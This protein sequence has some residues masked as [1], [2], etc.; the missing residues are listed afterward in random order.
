MKHKSIT[1]AITLLLALAI[2]IPLTTIPTTSG[3]STW[4]TYPYIGVTPNPVGVGQEVLLHVGITQE[5]QLHWMGWE[6]LTVTVTKPDGTTETLGPF[7]TDS[8]GGTG[9]IY[10]PNMVGN[11]TLQTHFPQQL[12]PADIGGGQFSTATIPKDTIM[13]ESSSRVLTLVVQDQAIPI[14]P[15]LPLPTEYWTRP[16]DAQL[17]E[18]HSISGNWVTAPENF[19]ALYN[20]D[21]PETAH[22]LWTKTLAMGGL[23][24]GLTGRDQLAHSFEDGDAYEGKFGQQAVSTEVPVIIGGI[25]Y[26][27]RFEARGDPYAKQ[28]VVAVNLH[29]GEELWC[30]PL[31]G[32]TGTTTGHTV[33]AANRVI[34]GKSDQFPDGIG[35]RLAFGQAFY[36]DSFNYHGVFGYLW[37]VSGTTWMAFDAL[38]GRWIY[39]ITD[40]P[41]GTT[42]YGPS[43]ELLRIQINQ[44]Q[45]WMA[46]WNATKIVNAQISGASGDGSW[47]PHGN[48]YNASGN[49]A[50]VRAAWEWNVTI[51]TGL[52]GS[53]YR[54][55]LDDRVVG[56]AFN[57]TNVVTWALSLKQ[58]QVGQ[59]LFN[60]N[61]NAPAVWNAGN[62]TISRSAGSIDEG[63]ITYWS[64]E[65]NQHWAFSTNTGDLLWGPTAPQNYLDLFGHRAAIAYGKFFSQ[66][67]SGILYCYDA[68]TGQLL[69]TYEADD[70]YNQVLW[71]NQWHIR[72]LIITDGK[73][74]MGTSEHS[75]VDPKPKGG[76]FVCVDVE[77]GQEIWRADGLFRQTDWGARAIIGDSII[78]T[79]DTYDQRIYAIGRGPSAVTVTA[80]GIRTQLGT[81]IMIQGTV[82]DIS[83]GTKDPALTMRFPNGVPAVADEYMSDWMLYV[84]KQF[85]RP[86]DATG[87]EVTIDVID[88]N[89]N[90]RNIGTTTSDSSGFYSFEWQPDIEG[91][92]TIIASFAGSKSYWP[93]YAQAAFA[94]DEATLQPTQ[95]PAV[96]LP[97]TELYIIGTGIA[98]IA[99]IALATLLILKKR[100]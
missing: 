33:T 42:L 86:M 9:T 11:Y 45:G 98:I 49:H 20:E 92:Y 16:I 57:R 3:Q 14:W 18:W 44:A 58:G 47:R 100:P 69:W 59:L 40:V 80:P 60:K 41:T 29:T 70:P 25:L 78:A 88:A 21:A 63:L 2:A 68:K 35:R 38:T 24:G 54:Y 62:Q 12:S 26:Y 71:A 52:P 53:A 43:G 22:I 28:E 97:P 65:T 13:K 23:A 83:P 87:V 8:T 5:L 34:D 96:D 95:Q 91:K 61:W 27:N 1:T 39:T 37:T 51:P 84:Y 89:G 50:N 72:P 48:V 7:R 94:V 31:I 17:H 66:G 55:K 99:A 19:F 74:Y 75:P 15:G 30:M 90:Y 6:G 56:S 46:L 4:T 93:A 77:T 76:P 10:V 79:M 32:R 64:K 36:W 67:M 82:S 85:P 73:I 81:P